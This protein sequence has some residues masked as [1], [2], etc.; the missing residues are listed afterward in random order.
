MQQI[1]WRSPLARAL[2]FLN[3]LFL[4][5]VDKLAGFFLCIRWKIL[6]LLIKYLFCPP[7]IAA[8][9]LSKTKPCWH[10]F[11]GIFKNTEAKAVHCIMV[12]LA[13]CFWVETRVDTIHQY[14]EPL[15]DHAQL[16]T[17]S[18]TVRL[19]DKKISNRYLNVW[20]VVNARINVGINK[21]NMIG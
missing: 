11:L 18:I 13:P 9:T 15:L 4:P 6:Y 10:F 19:D 21:I 3:K 12:F 7:K 20:P 16:L 1:S 17:P 8:K 14:L 5:G 2:D